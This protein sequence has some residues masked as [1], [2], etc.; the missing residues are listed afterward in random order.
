MDYTHP[1]IEQLILGK[2][3]YTITDEAELI[4]GIYHFVRDEI[5]YG[6]TKSFAIPASKVIEEGVGNGITKTTLFMALVRAV[7]IPCRF[8]AMTI[9]K[10]IFR[11]LISGLCFRL[12][13]KHLFRACVE[14]QSQETW[15]PWEGYIIDRPY[16]MKLQQRFFDHKGGF[17]GYGIGVLDFKNPNDR[18]SNN[19]IIMQNKSFEKDL[20]TFVTPDAFFSAIPRAELYAKTLQYQTIIC[21][22]LNKSILEVR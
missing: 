2:G 21:N 4:M 20:G 18:W 6:Y 5:A 14:L 13:D 1:T 17:Y 19:H 15:D 7:G 9:S 8:H 10:V 16:M 12:A 22:S 11:G 3:W